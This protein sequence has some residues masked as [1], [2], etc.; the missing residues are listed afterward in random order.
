MWPEAIQPSRKHLMALFEAAINHKGFS[1]VD[2]L[3]PCF[4]FFDTYDFYNERV[5]EFT[6][7]DHDASDRVGCF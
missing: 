1:F 3:Q 5:Y 4:T 7:Q 2:V 6:Q